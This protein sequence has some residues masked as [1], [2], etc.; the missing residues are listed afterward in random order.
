MKSSFSFAGV[1][2]KPSSPCADVEQA[3]E[4]CLNQNE[5]D[6]AGRFET[7]IM[8]AEE[9][10]SCQTVAECGNISIQGNECDAETTAAFNCWGCGVCDEEGADM[11]ECIESA[12]LEVEDVGDCFASC[13]EKKDE[14]KTCEAG[15]NLLEKCH[16]KCLSRNCKSEVFNFAHCHLDHYGVDCTA[17]CPA[18]YHESPV[19]SFASNLSR[20]LKKNLRA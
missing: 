9:E 3:A 1:H 4:T 13:A 18:E 12:G 19:Q 6:A 7:C 17:T 14:P 5:P 11:V 8:E 16:K 15:C 20:A 10:I 2:D